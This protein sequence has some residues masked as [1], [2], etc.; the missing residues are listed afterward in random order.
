MPYVP[1]RMKIIEI[2]VSLVASLPQLVQLRR[3]LA[4][5]KGLFFEHSPLLAQSIQCLNLLI[6]GPKMFENRGNAFL[7]SVIE[8]YR[9]RNAI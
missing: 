9:I 2:K 3:Q 6:H 7:V 8:F 5:I 4:A 1:Q